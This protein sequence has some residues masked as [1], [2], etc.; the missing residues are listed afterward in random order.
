MPT[1][2][3]F[4]IER[5]IGVAE[6]LLQHAGRDLAAAAAAVR[7]LREA[8]RRAF[9][10]VH[11]DSGSGER[12]GEMDRARAQ[13]VILAQRSALRGQRVLALLQK[14]DSFQLVASAAL[15]LLPGQA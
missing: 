14:V 1:S 5:R 10:S 3:S 11:A 8:Q 7:V 9:G 6:D 4:G 2:S 15:F 13:K 12:R